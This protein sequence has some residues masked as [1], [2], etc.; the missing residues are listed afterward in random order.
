MLI[1]C[2]S[3]TTHS[4]SNQTFYRSNVGLLIPD[5]LLDTCQRC[6]YIEKNGNLEKLSR[7]LLALNPASTEQE[8]AMGLFVTKLRNT[9]NDESLKVLAFM[10]Q[11]YR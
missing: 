4:L 6:F 2:M 3:T 10:R 1:Q 7:V 11:C 8:K 9:L 5:N